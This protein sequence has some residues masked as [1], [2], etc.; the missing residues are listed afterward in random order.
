MEATTADNIDCTKCHTRTMERHRFP[1]D[2]CRSCHSPDMSTLTLKDG[3]I[4]P[5]KRSTLLC[6]QCHKEIYQAWKEEKHGLISN[7]CAEC[8]NPHFKQQQAVSGPT[9]TLLSTVLQA[10]IATGIIIGLSLTA[11]LAVIIKRE[12]ARL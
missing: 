10:L 9:S 11:T 12:T 5:I 6:A 1:T 8:H 7:D 4:I 2:P 3:N